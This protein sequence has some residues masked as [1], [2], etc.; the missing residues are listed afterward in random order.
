[1][2]AGPQVLLRALTAQRFVGPVTAED[3]P[4]NR[5]LANELG[6]SL[7]KFNRKLDHLC[8]KFARAG[9]QGVVGSAFGSATQRRVILANFVVENRL[10]DRDGENP[11]V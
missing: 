3:L 11:T 4:S 1:M 8:K 6:W 7:P 2:D 9:V 5:Q 10:L